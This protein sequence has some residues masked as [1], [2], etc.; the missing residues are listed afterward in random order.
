MRCY[1]SRHTVSVL[2]KIIGLSQGQ[3]AELVGRSKRTI[4][5]IE[6]GRLKLSE[7]LAVRIAHET[8]VTVQWLL[9]ADYDKPPTVAFSD[10]AYTKRTYENTRAAITSTRNPNPLA[11]VLSQEDRS[12]LEFAPIARMAKFVEQTNSLL[13]SEIDYQPASILSSI[14]AAAKA[15][16]ARLA[17]YRLAEFA[18]TMKK[19]FGQRFDGE[20]TNDA[21]VVFEQGLERVKMTEV[22][23]KKSGHSLGEIPKTP[24]GKSAPIRQDL[25]SDGQLS[26]GLDE[27]EMEVI[28]EGLNHTGA[29]IKARNLALQKSFEGFQDQLMAVFRS[30]QPTGHESEPPVASKNPA[31]VAAKP[32]TPTAPAKPAPTTNTS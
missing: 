25:L 9:A 11:S 12:L 20:F 8:G 7:E 15:A 32:A 17:I 21:A 6:I 22:C 28:W 16:Q 29:R 5:A 24:G 19:E 27:S 4:Q 26:L 18:K 31:H 1:D 10:Q 14:C 23:I 2:R 3:L 30:A 13:H